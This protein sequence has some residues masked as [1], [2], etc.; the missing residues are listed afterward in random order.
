MLLVLSMTSTSAA[1][2]LGEANSGAGARLTQIHLPPLRLQAGA[3]AATAS[4][5]AASAAASLVSSPANLGGGGGVVGPPGEGG[6][7][8][9]GGGPP[10]SQAVGL[11]SVGPIACDA[12][13]R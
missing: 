6:G 13:H 7:G 9:G 8:G 5:A 11:P 1:V 2:Q 10:G 3:A 4:N 12:K